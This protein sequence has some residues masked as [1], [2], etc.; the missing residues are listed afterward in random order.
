MEVKNLKSANIV[1]ISIQSTEAIYGP[2]V[3][4]SWEEGDTEADVGL[5]SV[6]TKHAEVP[7]NEGSPI[8][9]HEKDLLST[10]RV[11]K[12][13]EITHYVRAGVAAD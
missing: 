10:Q 7:T 3:G 6:R 2:D 12:C 11:Q 1:V 4:V 5:D 13:N 8:M 9:T